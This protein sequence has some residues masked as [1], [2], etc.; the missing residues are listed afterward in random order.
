M[1]SR[2]PAK[3]RDCVVPLLVTLLV[4]GPGGA[5]AHPH[6]LVV[7]SIVLS[8][9]P[10]GVDR[11]GFV[12]TFDP[13]FSAIILSRTARP[14]ETAPEACTEG[15]GRPSQISRQRSTGRPPTGSS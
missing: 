9:P 8:L 11:I 13:L 5:Q 6:A 7:Y 12:F 1:W 4:G 10:G 3:W 15:F 2:S 14:I